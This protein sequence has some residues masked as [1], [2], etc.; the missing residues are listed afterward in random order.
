[1]FKCQEC[2]KKFKSA[3]ESCPKC[4]G[5]DIDLDEAI[6][7]PR[8]KSVDEK[9][10]LDQNNPVDCSREVWQNIYSNPDYDS[11]NDFSMNH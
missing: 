1:M 8:R 4:G 3:R 2:G 6:F 9:S 11:D 5:C 7:V 10:D